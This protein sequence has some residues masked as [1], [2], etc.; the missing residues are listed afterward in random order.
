MKK[1]FCL[2]L[3]F[4][5][6][7]GLTVPAMGETENSIELEASSAIL[8]D[9]KSGRVL[10]EKDADAKRYPAST[11]KILTALLAI[12]NLDPEAIVTI[13]ESAVD[14]DRDGSNMGLLNGE[15]LTVRQ[16]LYGLLVDSANDAANAL[17]EEVAGSQEAFT[18]RMNARAAELG[19]TGSNFMN[20]HGYH[21]DN[22]YTT[23][24]DLCLI[25][26]E[27][28]KYQLFSEIVSTTKYQI[29][30]TNKYHEI[31]EFSNRNALI[32]PAMGRKYLFSAATGIKTGH[33]SKAGKCLVASAEKDGAEY[34]C[35]VLDAP[36]VDDVNHSFAD[37]ITLFNYAFKNYRMQ[38]LSDTEEIV[39]TKEVQWASGGAQAVLSTKEPLRVLLPVGYDKSK[40]ETELAIPD[41]VTAP[42]AEGQA[43]GHIT[44]SYDGYTLGSVELVNKKEVGISYIRMIFGTILGWLLSAWV[45]VPLGILVAI[46]LILRWNELRRQKKLR[47]KRK[48]AS[49]RNF[50][51]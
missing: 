10:Y 46:I 13:S 9:A 5:V 50:Y 49:R 27:A 17:G 11:T 41:T 45:M 43:V 15:E 23:A 14:I 26:R 38:T 12:E 39:A 48:N 24:R 47:E 21:D 33:T 51:R 22:H 16:L 36:Q 32:N 35:V 29:E 4:I 18:Q 2:I 34:L 31:R 37:P 7:A 28:M 6:L 1:M 30:P 20:P 44:Y 3:A 42:V 8:M 40:L 19:A 25:A